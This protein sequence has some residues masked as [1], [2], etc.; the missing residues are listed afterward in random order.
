MYISSWASAVPGIEPRIPIVSG[1]A[2]ELQTSIVAH[3]DAEPVLGFGAAPSATACE[4]TSALIAATRPAQV[5]VP[6]L[7]R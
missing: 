7:P 2:A 5:R 3:S 4:T 1:C 6:T